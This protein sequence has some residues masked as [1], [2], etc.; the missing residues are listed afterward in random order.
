MTNLSQRAYS[1]LRQVPKGKV[2]T[3]KA[4]ADALGTKAYRAIGQAMRRNPD[5][6]QVPCHRVVT[7]NGTI[8]GFMGQSSGENITRKKLLLA[9]EGIQISGNKIVNF[10][11][12]CHIFATDI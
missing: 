9:R 5:A 8:G 7:V 1:L 11:A 3:Y 12:V 4:L 2:T 6:P 10:A